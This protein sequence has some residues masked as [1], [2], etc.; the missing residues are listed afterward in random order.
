M[1][2]LKKF[3]IVTPFSTPT[4][5]RYDRASVYVPEDREEQTLLSKATFA[6]EIVAGQPLPPPPPPK[7]AVVDDDPEPVQE[8]HKAGEEPDWNFMTKTAMRS[9]LDRSGVELPSA[10]AMHATYV[11][12]CRAAWQGGSRPDPLYGFPGGRVPSPGLPGPDATDPKLFAE[13][14]RALEDDGVTVPEEA[15]AWFTGL[16]GTGPEQD[17]REGAK[18]PAGE[19]IS[20]ETVEPSRSTNVAQAGSEEAE[21]TPEICEGCP[22]LA[23]TL[24]REGVSLCQDCY[25]ALAET[26]EVEIQKAPE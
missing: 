18:Q 3:R 19:T 21:P 2:E 15:M 26:T 22:A 16:Q 4:G 20:T 12:Q 9:W 6:V 13:A 23:T 8:E 1:P 5:K 10:R 24:D 17:A 14:L 25:D 11:A 7:P